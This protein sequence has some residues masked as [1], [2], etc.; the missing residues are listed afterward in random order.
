MDKVQELID[1]H[2]DQD[3]SENVPTLGELAD[4]LSP[5]PNQLCYIIDCRTNEIEVISGSI[6]K[7]SGIK[8][9]RL[10]EMHHLFE[11]MS[12]QHADFYTEFCLKTIVPIVKQEVLLDWR[13]P[14]LNNRATSFTITS[15]RRI[16]K[17]S[18]I[19]SMDSAQNMIY[20]YGY[21]SD[22]T[23][24]MPLQESKFTYQ[25]YGSLSEVFYSYVCDIPDF[26][27]ILSG[28][29][30]EVMAL[31]SSGLNG[32]QISERLCISKHTVDKHR[33]NILK[34]LEVN[35]S[36]QAYRKAFDMGLL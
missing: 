28:R 29:E 31:I 30:L 2:I 21:L 22:V 15:G 6:E 33:K 25:F 34:K 12:G 10:R 3:F 27:H 18:G 16:L 13:Q 19:L 20:T 9:Y 4:Q 36:V 11:Y 35:N 5:R 32:T 7:V 23:D 26:R 1:L 17:E 24:L 8:G 14:Q